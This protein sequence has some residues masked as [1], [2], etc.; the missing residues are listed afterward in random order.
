MTA[1]ISGGLFAAARLT[2]STLALPQAH[3]ALGIFTAVVGLASFVG[4]LI[5]HL[6]IDRVL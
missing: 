2:H 4:Q 6:T 5:T 3:A 1:L